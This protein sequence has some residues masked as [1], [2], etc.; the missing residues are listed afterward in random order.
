LWWEYNQ[1]LIPVPP[2]PEEPPLGVPWLGDLQDS[3]KEEIFLYSGGTLFTILF[4][5]IILIPLIMKKRKRLKRVI[6]ARN[7][8][9]ST[10]SDDEFED[11]FD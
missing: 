2:A 8:R 9:K 5:S 10:I 7:R 3:M 6:S 11:F 4:L 1:H